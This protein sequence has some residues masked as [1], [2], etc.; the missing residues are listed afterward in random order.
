MVAVDRNR[1]L[2]V[3]DAV[4]HARDSTFQPQRGDLR[5]LAERGPAL[6]LLAGREPLSALAMML[7]AVCSRTQTT[8]GKP[9]F[10]RYAAVARPSRAACSASSRSRPA[11]DCSDAE[12]SVSAAQPQLLPR[13]LRMRP[14]Q[15]ELAL[16][17]RT[18]DRPDHRGVQGACRGSSGSGSR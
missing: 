5:D 15:L 7:A 11:P 17:G 8:N 14:D 16:G 4:V 3:R 13:E 10:S 1:L 18:L 12:A 9:N 2:P 6:L